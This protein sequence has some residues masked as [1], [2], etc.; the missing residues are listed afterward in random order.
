MQLRR[1][2]ARA[3][4]FAYAYV[5]VSRNWKVYLVKLGDRH[6]VTL[7]LKYVDA[8]IFCG[9]SSALVYCLSCTCMCIVKAPAAV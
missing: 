1:S 3:L 6:H 5:H 2:R 7:P 4:E 8:L 9:A